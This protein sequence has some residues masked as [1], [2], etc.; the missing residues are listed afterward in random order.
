VMG[1]CENLHL[2]ILSTQINYYM[3]TIGGCFY[4]TGLNKIV[5]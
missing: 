3:K 5:F 1:R 4:R 2:L